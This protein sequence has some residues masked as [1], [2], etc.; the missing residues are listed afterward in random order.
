MSIWFAESFI[1]VVLCKDSRRMGSLLEK[2]V[3]G[4]FSWWRV[5]IISCRVVHL[6]LSNLHL[7]CRD[8]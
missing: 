4:G 1:G 5:C 2:F 3:D 7:Y 6:V 8:A